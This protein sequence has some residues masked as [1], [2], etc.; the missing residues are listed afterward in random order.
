MGNGNGNGRYLAQD[1]ISAI[2]GSGGIISTI[3]KRVGCAWHTAKK[4]VETMPTV[5]QAYV[6]ECEAVTDMAESVLL[7]SIQDGDVA[8]AKW[9]LTKKGRQR[10]F[11]DQ[12][13]LT[14]AGGGP[15]VVV[16]WDESDSAA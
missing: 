8:S 1:F 2:P 4:Y 7:K 9:W 15:I 10:G 13:E 12:L 5:T 16:N 3:A 11:A 14:G 6:N